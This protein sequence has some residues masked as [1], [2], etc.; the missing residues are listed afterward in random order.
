MHSCWTLLVFIMWFDGSIE[1]MCY[2]H[3]R[4]LNEILVCKIERDVKQRHNK[5]NAESTASHDD[6]FAPEFKLIFF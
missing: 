2:V 5:M 6:S 1:K 4:F 3:A